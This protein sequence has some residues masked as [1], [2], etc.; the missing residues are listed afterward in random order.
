MIY[1]FEEKIVNQNGI[2]HFYD[3]NNFVGYILPN[4]NVYSCKM[5]NVS[6]VDTVLSMYLDLL[7]NHFDAKDD[8]LD[9]N[10]SDELLKLVINYLKKASHE[11]LIALKEFIR[12]NN[13]FISDLLVEL[14]GCHLVTRLDRTILTSEENHELFYNYLLNDFKI[15]NIDKIFYDNE[16]K[17]YKYIS[18]ILRN[19]YLY[20]EINS[21]KKSVNNGS[22]E[23]FYKGR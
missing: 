1:Q 17:E 18:C 23:L 21:I 11:E 22:I 9:I 13:V 2:N 14:F 6:N 12:N 8:L 19:D 4:G 16:T 5:H 3:K 20:D 10:S 15:V 7:V